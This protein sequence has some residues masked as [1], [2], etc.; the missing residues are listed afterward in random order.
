MFNTLNVEKF[1]FYNFTGTNEISFA[2]KKSCFAIHSVHSAIDAVWGSRVGV[3]CI[4]C[5]STESRPDAPPLWIVMEQGELDPIRR[6][7][8]LFFI[9]FSLLTTLPYDSS[10]FS[11]SLLLDSTSRKHVEM[12]KF[13]RNIGLV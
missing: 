8:C 11:G 6:P 12:S 9:C 3:H 13:K 2:K 5:T 4:L 1:Y 10:I 7:P